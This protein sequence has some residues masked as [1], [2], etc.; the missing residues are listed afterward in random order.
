MKCNKTWSVFTIILLTSSSIE[1]FCSENAGYF[2]WFKSAPQRALQQVGSYS[3]SAGAYLYQQ[4]A[5]LANKLSE[6]Y[7]IRLL[8]TLAADLDYNVDS[9]KAEKTSFYNDI[10]HSIKGINV[11]AELPNLEPTGNDPIP[12]LNKKPKTVNGL[13]Q[14][15]ITIAN[16]ISNVLAAA[17]KVDP[18]NIYSQEWTRLDE[19]LNLPHE[20]LVGLSGIPYPK[21]MSVLKDKAHL[22]VSVLPFIDSTAPY[23]KHRQDILR[24]FDRIQTLIGNINYYQNKKT[25]LLQ[26][27]KKLPIIDKDLT[28]QLTQIDQWLDKLHAMKQAYLTQ[29][30]LTE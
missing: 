1:V 12:E 4:V 20:T 8:T 28:T 30:G 29:S 26:E 2:S 17:V 7:K 22:A 3:S 24:L 9:K 15:V 14:Q 10:P 5:S 19:Q 25:T 27:Q 13:T 6:K 18:S 16:N 23:I 21:N 11:K